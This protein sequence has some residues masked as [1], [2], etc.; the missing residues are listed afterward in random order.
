M[1]SIL[2]SK[3]PF[4]LAAK[5][6]PYRIFFPM[7]I[8]CLILGTLIWLPQLW[9]VGSYPVLAHRY[10]MLNGFNASFIAGFLMTAVPKFS[11]TETPDI[12][13]VLCFFI[14]T[15][16]GL[17]FA[18]LENESYSY[19]AS[20]FQ[21][22]VLLFFL[23]RRISKRK[24]NPP[25]SFVF[26]FIGLILWVFS[27]FMGI[28]VHGDAF[29]NLHYEGSIAA[30]ILGVGSRLVPGILGHVEIVQTQRAHYEK[31]KPFL[32][33][34]PIHFYVMIILFVTS[35][36][37][38]GQLGVWIRS[39]V[40]IFI[41]LFYWKLYQTPKERTALTWN[42]W[43][44]CWLI[45]M[46]FILKA[47]WIGGYIHASHAFFFSGIVLLTLL[48]AT[49]VLQ[50]HGPKDKSLENLKILYVV[51]GLIIWAGVTRVSAYLM[52]EYYFRH[53]GYSSIILSIAVVLWGYRYL[54]Y[55]RK[56]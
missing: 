13:E 26:I 46:S 30:I 1:I 35:Y 9:N 39:I 3:T 25:Y 20:A 36:F 40:V 41:G 49:R 50:S 17:I 34:I 51:T 15:I 2:F 48:I 28:L 22:G 10:L 24:V 37:L 38:A 31:D 56:F 23:S 4:F 43:I 54:R 53:L 8:L 12:K 45:L 18:F 14:V 6:E 42:I 27:A 5:K 11:Q 21:A 32:L 52:P 44:S 16:L 7:G 19:L 47:Y 55:I 33:T 29:K